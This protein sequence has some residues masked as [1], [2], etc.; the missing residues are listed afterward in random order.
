VV[1]GLEVPDRPPPQ[2][3]A[4][5]DIGGLLGL[6]LDLDLD[7]FADRV[8]GFVVVAR[9]GV[10]LAGDVAGGRDAK[11][12]QPRARAQ[13][14]LGHQLEL[15]GPSVEQPHLAVGQHGLRWNVELDR[16]LGAAV[17]LP[18]AAELVA[19]GGGIRLKAR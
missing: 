9:H 3:F 16:D 15:A 14:I 8:V 10:A 11:P 5:G 19:V 1:L 17:A 4:D 2:E 6:V 13:R 18:G 12:R 7:R